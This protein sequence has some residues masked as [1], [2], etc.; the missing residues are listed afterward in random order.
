[1]SGSEQLMRRKMQKKEVDG[2]YLGNGLAD[3]GFTW[4]W[5]C[6]PWESLH[7]ETILFLVREQSTHYSCMKWR[8]RFSAHSFVMYLGASWNTHYCV[9]WWIQYV[10]LWADWAADTKHCFIR[11]NHACIHLIPNLNELDNSLAHAIRLLTMAIKMTKE[12]SH[13]EI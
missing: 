8:F 5:K 11:W 13:H 6:P 9:P 7:K 12:L 1:M 3:C 10:N 4:N 2:T